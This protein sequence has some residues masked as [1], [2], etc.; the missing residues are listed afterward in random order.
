MKIVYVSLIV[1]LTAVFGVTYIL[2]ESEKESNEFSSYEEAVKSGL[3]DRGWIPAFI[4]KSAY[5]IKE[6]HRVDVPRIHV[7]L[8]YGAD[9]I[10]DFEVA[11][12]KV[13]E[14]VYVCSNSGYPVKVSLTN[15]N[16]ATIRSVEYGT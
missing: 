4:P 3:I 12:D 5:D 1:A 11:C 9:D 16:C 15:E 14:G 6:K 7:D 10:K 2:F 8:K 13:R